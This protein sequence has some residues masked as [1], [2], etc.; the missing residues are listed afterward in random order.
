MAIS[1]MTVPRMMSIDA[2]RAAGGVATS[3][4]TAVMALMLSRGRRRKW[5]AGVDGAVWRL[6]PRIRPEWLNGTGNRPLHEL[7][8]FCE[9]WRAART[10]L[11]SLDRGFR[12]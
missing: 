7:E 1:T 11:I 3:R 4:R 9:R 10:K 12:A 5:L 8:A 2:M 6:T